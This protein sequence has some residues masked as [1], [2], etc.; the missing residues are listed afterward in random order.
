MEDK[1]ILCTV[2]GADFNF[3]AAEQEF[4]FQRVSRTKKMQGVPR[5]R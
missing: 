4:Y 1:Q 3:T 2:C 5:C